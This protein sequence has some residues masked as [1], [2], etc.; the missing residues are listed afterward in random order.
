[1]PPSARRV[2]V[3]LARGSAGLREGGARRAGAVRT[4]GAPDPVNAGSLLV[5]EG[6]DGSGKTTQRTRLAARLRAAGRDVLETAEPYD[7]GTWG[8]RIRTMARS[9]KTL[10]AAEELRWFLE[11]RREHVRERIA[12]ALAAGRVVLCDR[13]FLSTAAYQGARGLDAEA[14]LA[15]GEREF[16]LPDLVLLL[17]MEAARA[18]ERVAARAGPREPVFER[19]EFLERVAAN[20]QR[21]QRR[22]LVRIDADRGADAVEAD[23]LDAVRQRTKLLAAQAPCGPG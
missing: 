13:Y 10:P 3:G 11:Q 15:D 20:F 12:P 19:L 2:A 23:V 1:V 6:L 9:G 5:F 16:P 8:P 7:G 22:Y 18:L 4:P 14:I 17:E 21:L